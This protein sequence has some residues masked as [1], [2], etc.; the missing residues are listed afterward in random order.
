MGCAS[1]KNG[2]S[3]VDDSVHAMLAHEKKVATKKGEELH[4][5]VPRAPHPLLQ[6]KHSQSKSTEGN[7]TNSNHNGNPIVAT[8]DDD[9]NL[10]LAAIAAKSGQ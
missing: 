4:G 2:L 6:S 8:E 3:H 9:E 10:L 5:Y 7:A 1:S